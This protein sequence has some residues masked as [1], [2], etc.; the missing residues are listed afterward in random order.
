MKYQLINKVNDSWSAI[1]QV[2]HNRGV[3]DI[4]HYLNTSDQDIN[5]FY[6]FGRDILAQSARA[7]SNV[8]FNKE[9]AVVIVDSD[10]DGFTSSA[11]LINY[12]H[13]LFPQWVENKLD[14]ILHS[15]K[16][17]GLNDH[18]DYLLTKDYSLVLIP[19]AGSNDVGECKRLKEKN[20][21]IYKVFYY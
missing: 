21:K 19:D 7:L 17:H 16:Q 10:C 6:D 2:L 4:Q 9:K 11:V 15:G 20:I 8:I 1:E 14:Y 13:D 5:S 3:D 12:L 18:I